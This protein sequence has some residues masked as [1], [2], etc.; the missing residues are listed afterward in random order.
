MG[1]VINIAI[2][3]GIGVYLV[4]WGR[5]QRAKSDV[6][7]LQRRKDRFV[8][9]GLV[10]GTVGIILVLAWITTDGYGPQ[11]FHKWSLPL[12]VASMVGGFLLSFLSPWFARRQ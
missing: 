8:N 5:Q 3:I 12:A 9:A 11:W 7:P 6:S 1:T 4:R 10:V 2:A